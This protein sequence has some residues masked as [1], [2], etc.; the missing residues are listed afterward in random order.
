[1]AM[2]ALKRRYS[3]TAVRFPNLIAPKSL[4]M[5]ARRAFYSRV[6]ARLRECVSS[7][8]EFRAKYYVVFTRDIGIMSRL[9]KQYISMGSLV[10]WYLVSNFYAR[11]TMEIG[12][13]SLTNEH[14]QANSIVDAYLNQ[15]RQTPKARKVLGSYCG[16]S[17]LSVATSFKSSALLQDRLHVNSS[18]N[19]SLSFHSPIKSQSY[20]RVGYIKAYQ[21]YS[22]LSYESLASHLNDC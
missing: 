19:R 7:R 21:L 2:T 8:L 4:V 6:R 13:L 22:R 1:M 16:C 20:S 3:S 11:P 17:A 18:F 12:K 5:G 14:N 10:A 15:A 9:S